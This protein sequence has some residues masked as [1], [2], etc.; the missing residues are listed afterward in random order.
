MLSY[1]V[2]IH[3]DSDDDN[4]DDDGDDKTDDTKKYAKMFI[5]LTR[6]VNRDSKPLCFLQSTVMII[7]SCE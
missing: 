5:I 6:F 2:Q 3:D 7:M 4:D 1:F